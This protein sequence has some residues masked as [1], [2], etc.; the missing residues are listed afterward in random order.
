MA[1]RV[2]IETKTVSLT[3]KGI[4]KAEKG[5]KI[6][7]LYDIQHTSLVHHINQALKANYAMTRDV[8]YMIA[9]EDGTRDIRNAK[10]MIIDQLMTAC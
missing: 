7:N 9:T 6:D 10:I 8:E 3:P 5:F 4:E 1:R 2:D